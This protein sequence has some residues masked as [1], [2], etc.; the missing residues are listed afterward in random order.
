MHTDLGPYHLNTKHTDLVKHRWVAKNFLGG[1]PADSIKKVSTIL[2]YWCVGC[3]HVPVKQ[4]YI[5]VNLLQL[6]AL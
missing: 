6:G 1:D 5:Q 2:I 3:L 4:F